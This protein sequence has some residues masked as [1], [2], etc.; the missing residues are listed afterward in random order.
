MASKKLIKFGALCSLGA[1]VFALPA[2]ANSAIAA[3]TKAKSGTFLGSAA[4][5]RFGAVQVAV[6]V[7]SGKI[8]NEDV[9]KLGNEFG[10]SM[11]VS[12]NPRLGG[13]VLAPFGEPGGELQVAKSKIKD[14][15]GSDMHIKAGHSD[16][17]KDRFYMPKA[18]YAQEGARQTPR[19]TKELR[20][21]LKRAE[22]LRYREPSFLS[23]T[24]PLTGG[25]VD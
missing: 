5:T 17:Q 4:Q 9:I 20:Q 16:L 3:T 25:K 1:A 21:E 18:E 13:V 22:A 15:F 19:S 24:N 11:V 10:N 23:E 12:H 7:K 6:T 14:L 2:Q 8:T